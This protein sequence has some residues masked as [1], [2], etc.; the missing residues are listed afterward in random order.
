[1]EKAR[2]LKVTLPFTV[3]TYD[4]DFAGHVSNIVYIRWLED[5]RLHFLDVHFPLEEQMAE[6]FAPILTRTQIDYKRALRL[7]D[8]PIEG[9][10]WFGDAGRIKWRL[11]AEFLV[12]GQVAATS[13]QH[14]VFIN[15][16]T[17][18]PIPIPGQLRER[19][20]REVSSA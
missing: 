2:P 12:G 5:L 17:H 9:H 15:M 8:R 10:M 1:M 4:I 16:E 11:E 7:F 20:N 6:S 14:G 3:K 18:R 19:Y 13:V